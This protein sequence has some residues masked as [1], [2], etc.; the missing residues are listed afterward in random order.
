MHTVVVVSLFA[1]VKAA[2]LVAALGTA[3]AQP[4]VTVCQ[5]QGWGWKG[6]GGVAPGFRSVSGGEAG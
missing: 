1:F 2:L 3:E 4:Q 6:T 5:V